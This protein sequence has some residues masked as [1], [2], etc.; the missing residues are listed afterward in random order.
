MSLPHRLMCADELLALPADDRRHELV[1]GLRVSEPPASF[2]HGAIAAEVFM[3]L[4]EHVRRQDLGRVLSTE[5]GFLLARNPDTVR[6]PDVAFVSRG[7]IELAGEISGYFP[8][9]P[10]LAVEVLS[11][12]ERPADVHAKIGD[13]LAAGSRVV[14]VIDPSRR[15][16][17]VH[18]SLLQPAI[19]DDTAT[20]EADDLLPGFGVR[21]ESLFP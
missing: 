4:S 8:G 3:R 7:R 13:Y 15:Q 20:L 2:R 21:V 9:A 19:L 6:A 12:S 11:P 16:V 18:R 1:A 17:R 10:D 5:T 14:W